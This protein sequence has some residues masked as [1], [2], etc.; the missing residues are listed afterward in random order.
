MQTETIGTFFHR[1]EDRCHNN[2]LNKLIDVIII[3]ICGVVA[4][5]DSYKQIKNFG[6]NANNGFQKI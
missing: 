3:A 5:A 2:K 4:G 6:K 1:I